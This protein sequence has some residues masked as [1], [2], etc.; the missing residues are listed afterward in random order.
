MAYGQSSLNTLNTPPQGVFYNRMSAS[1]HTRGHRFAPEF[2]A[3]VLNCW[4]FIIGALLIIQ[5][6][7]R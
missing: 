4:K 1:S 3:V 7:Y 5:E 2:T 6:P